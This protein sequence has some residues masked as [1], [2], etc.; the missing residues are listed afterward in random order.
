MASLNE[1]TTENDSRVPPAPSSWAERF[2][3]KCEEGFQTRWQRSLEVLERTGRS[4]PQHLLHS[5]RTFWHLSAASI[6]TLVYGLLPFAPG[7]LQAHAHARRA[8]DLVEGD[9][10]LGGEDDEE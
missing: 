10:V 7:D 5:L 3:S 1:N 9:L 2:K 6:A 8:V 4:Y